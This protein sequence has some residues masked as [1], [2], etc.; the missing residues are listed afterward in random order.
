MTSFETLT[1]MGNVATVKLLY[2]E[3]LRCLK[4]K[5]FQRHA[6]S[7]KVTLSYIQHNVEYL[8]QN[9]CFGIVVKIAVA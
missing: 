9:G 2:K 1:S 7:T 5:M 3:Q 4:I 8:S 6:K